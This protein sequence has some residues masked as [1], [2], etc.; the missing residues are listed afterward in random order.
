MIFAAFG[1]V[2][3]PFNRMAKAIDELAYSINEEVIVQSGYTKYDFRY[4]TCIPFMNQ[5]EFF[6]HLK[7]ASVVI[8]QGGWGSISEASDLRCKI[9]SV[10]RVKGLEHNH[11]QIQLVKKLEEMRI[12]LAVYEISDLQTKVIEA[13]TFNFKPI[14]R[15]SAYEVIVSSLNDWLK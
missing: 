1:N 10:P 6:N 5:S 14:K 11:D 13:K 7:Q 2:P 12:L 15:G 9:V 3:T 8:L 4:A